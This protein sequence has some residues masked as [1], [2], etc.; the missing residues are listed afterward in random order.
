MVVAYLSNPRVVFSRG[1]RLGGVMWRRRAALGVLGVWGIVSLVRLSRLIEP[2]EAPPGPEL[3]PVLE[4][5]RATIPPT[6]GYLYVEPGEFGRDTGAGQRLRYELYPR[7]YDDVRAS[8]DEAVVRQ[9]V[10]A[11]GLG[12][13]VVPE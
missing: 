12:Y 1:A 7:A 13:V 4:F 2:P 5:F 6:A 3:G 10:G 11:E 8:V 9:L